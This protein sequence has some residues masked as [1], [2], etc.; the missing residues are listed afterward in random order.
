MPLY[1]KE[2]RQKMVEHGLIRG[3]SKKEMGQK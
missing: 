1:L 3:R 2:M